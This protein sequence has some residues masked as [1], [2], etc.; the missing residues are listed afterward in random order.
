MKRRILILGAGLMQ[1]PA[2]TFA[3]GMGLETVVADG[4]P[5]AVCA[6]LADRFE[7]I[8]LKDKEGLEA[9]GRALMNDGGLSAVMT[10][11]TDFSASVA[12]V[13]EKLG[14]PGIPYET[15]LDA[16]DKERMRR[17]FKEAGVPSP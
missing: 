14:L 9:L 7:N 17:R 5:Q 4:D 2:I 13:A 15:A 3:K 11:G 12:W 16:S 8:D 6:S 10:A 1:K